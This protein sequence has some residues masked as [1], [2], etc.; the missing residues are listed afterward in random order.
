VAALQ[1]VSGIVAEECASALQ[2]F[3]QRYG[4]DVRLGPVLVVIAALNEE[5]SIGEVLDH[6]APEVGGLRVDVLVVDECD[7]FTDHQPWLTLLGLEIV[8]VRNI[9]A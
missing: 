3:R 8:F 6:I 2:D 1:Q 9:S 5:G 7:C 4:A